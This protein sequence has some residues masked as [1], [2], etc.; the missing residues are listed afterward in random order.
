M[1]K[2]AHCEKPSS[3]LKRCSRCKVVS[4]CD[5]ECQ[6]A[7]Y[8]QHKEICGKQFQE[9]GHIKDDADPAV[10]NTGINNKRCN[11]CHYQM[12]PLMR[13]SRCKT[14]KYCSVACQR[15][16]YKEHTVF[17]QRSMRFQKAYAQIPAS[18]KSKASRQSKSVYTSLS[19]LP[20]RQSREYISIL[21]IV[22]AFSENS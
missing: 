2:C 21:M 20:P 12:K 5:I 14:V 9:P 8:I 3:S 4:Y 17:C 6:R 22:V 13:C 15:K 1:D 18:L 7:H 16:D 10:F 11:H 19:K